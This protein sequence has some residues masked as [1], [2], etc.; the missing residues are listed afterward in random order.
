MKKFLINI[1]YSLSFKK[2]F[3]EVFVRTNGFYQK[4]FGLKTNKQQNYTKENKTKI[5]KINTVHFIK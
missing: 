5:L 2:Q 4:R 1:R 3:F